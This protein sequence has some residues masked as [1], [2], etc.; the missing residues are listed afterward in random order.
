[1]IANSFNQKS[2]QFA[3][4]AYPS[5][6]RRAVQIDAFAGIDLRL[7]VERHVVGILRDQHISEQPRPDESSIDRPRRCRSLHGPVV[8]VAAQLRAHMADDLEAGSYALQHLGEI[9]AQLA[10]SAAAVGAGFMGGHV[11]VDL[12]RKMLR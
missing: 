2:K 7:P 1:V 6:Q 12:A 4:R 10:Q 3:R 11:R 8:G 9:L 5:G